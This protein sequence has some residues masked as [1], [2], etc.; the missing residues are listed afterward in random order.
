MSNP[1]I[2]DKFEL[3]KMVAPSFDF[4]APLTGP[5]QLSNKLQLTTFDQ[6]LYGLAA[7][8]VGLNTRVIYIRGFSSAMFNP[9][10]VD[11]AKD[12]LYLEE[13]S[14]CYPGLILKVKRPDII[15]VRWTDAFGNTETNI[16]SGLTSATIQRKIDYLDGISFID[17]A[18]KYHRDKALKKWKR[19]AE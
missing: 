12:S 7:N 4:T 19:N 17:R 2:F 9:I 11:S 14:A 3:P 13:T 10:I 8:Q 1:D 18:T 15:K 5:V 6:N 16:Y